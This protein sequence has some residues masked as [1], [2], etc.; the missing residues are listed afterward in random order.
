[1]NARIRDFIRNALLN[2]RVNNCA[3][4][5]FEPLKIGNSWVGPFKACHRRK[6]FFTSSCGPPSSRQRL[7]FLPQFFCGRKSRTRCHPTLPE[8]RLHLLEDRQVLLENIAVGDP[9]PATIGARR[10]Q[11][12]LFYRML[13]KVIQRGRRERESRGVLFVYVEGFARLRTKLEAFFSIL[14]MRF[15]PI[16]AHAQIHFQRHGEA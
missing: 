3:V 14:G 2:R 12:L 13:K 6:C 16:A 7:S 4:V 11:F 8:R 1:M 9:S 10:V 15:A 5:E